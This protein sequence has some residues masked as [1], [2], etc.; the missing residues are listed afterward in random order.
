MSA[1]VTKRTRPNA[2]VPSP[3][4][5][6]TPMEGMPQW[7]RD[8]LHEAQRRV[9]SA[10][11]ATMAGHLQG[12]F[13][14]RITALITGVNDPKTVGRWIRGQEPQ[15]SHYRRLQ[16]AYHVITLLEVAESEQVARAWF[17][18]MNPDLDNQAPA[19]VL[20]DDPIYGAQRIMRAAH[21]YLAHG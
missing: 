13:G 16:D 2:D 15:E 6:L 17:L 1:T 7:A 11:A 4:A 14:Q 5:A 20:T 10:S 9:V 12:L 21:S 19:A 3:D 8:L 18:G